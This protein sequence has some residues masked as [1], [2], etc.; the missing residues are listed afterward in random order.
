MDPVTQAIVSAV[1]AGITGRVTDVAKQAVVDAYNALKGALKKRFGD[2][3]KIVAAVNELEK[4][5]DFEPNA[6]AV[7]GRVAQVKADEDEEILA[8]AQ[9]LLDKLK[10]QPGGEGYIKQVVKDSIGVAQATGGGTAT[11]TMGEVP[12]KKK[13]K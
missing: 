1:A 4:E 8:A 9:A 7:A 11:V 10:A 2:D 12:E 5:P 13:K 3:S 6:D